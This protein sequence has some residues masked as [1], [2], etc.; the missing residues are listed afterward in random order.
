MTFDWDP[1]KAAENRKKYGLSFERAITA[2]DDPYAL[3][4]LDPEHSTQTEVREWLIGKSDGDVVVVV[5]TVRQPGNVYRIIS[6]RNATRDERR[7]Y[8]ESKGIPI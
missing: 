4:A 1:E 7:S 6:A 8:E 5:F 2:F 3:I